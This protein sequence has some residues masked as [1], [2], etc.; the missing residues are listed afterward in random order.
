MIAFQ[1]EARIARTLDAIRCADEIVVVDGGSTD[2]TAELCRARG[3]RVLHRPFDG[4]G[5]QKGFAVSQAAHDWVLNLD[6]DEELTPALNEEIRALLARPAIEEA[7][8]RLPMTLVFLGRAFRHGKH[9]AERHV[10][11]FDRT[12]AAY[13]ENEVHEGVV[14]RGPVGALRARLFHHSF[15][16]LDH[17]VAKM[18]DYTSRGARMLHAAGARRSAAL[19]VAAWPFYFLKSYLLQRNFL[20]GAPGLIWSFFFSLQPV[21]KYLKLAAL[22]Q[23]EQRR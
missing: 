14:P 13:N 16:D 6:A 8:F 20:N 17:F 4:F 19:A 22:A 9:A 5:R 7:A 11:L 18:N 1:E 23:G 10:R 2:R 12:R 15:R 21:V 3:C